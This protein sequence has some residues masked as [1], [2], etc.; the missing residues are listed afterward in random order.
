MARKASDLMSLLAHR[1]SMRRRSS[2]SGFLQQVG[3]SLRAVVVG[4]RDATAP[5]RNSR[6]SMAVVGAALACVG[7]GYLLG[8]VFPW[9]RAP[10]DLRVGHPGTRTGVAPAIQG[11]IDEFRPLASQ[12][13]LTAAYPE[14][15]AAKAAAAALRQH[16]LQSARLQELRGNDG[17]Q[18]FGLV[19]YFDGARDQEQLRAGLQG[20]PAPDQ[21]FESCRKVVEGWPLVRDLR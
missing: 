14:L 18:L 4:R 7:T 6:A 9:N 2:R 20:I 10:T 17:K 13:F 15:P 8:N 21:T 3:T 1:G 16:G 19:V 12:C 11:E 5:R